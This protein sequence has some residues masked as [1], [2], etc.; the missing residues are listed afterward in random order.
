MT[1]VD[2]S[3][4]HKPPE[5]VVRTDTR[6]AGQVKRYH[7]WPC[8]TE[9]NIAEHTWDVLRIMYFIWTYLPPPV[10]KHV[11][12]HDCGEL[13]TG[14]LPYP[15]K[16][17]HPPVKKLMDELEEQSLKDQ[18]VDCPT[19]SKGW[20]ARV[21]IAHT[22]EMMEFAMH[23]L[24]LGNR[25]AAYVAN[26]MQQYLKEQ[27][28]DLPAILIADE[29]AGPVQCTRELYFVRHYVSTREARYISVMQAA[30]DVVQGFVS[31]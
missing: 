25:Y 24:S 20:A 21:K 30:T 17:L 4:T 27:L 1:T 13:R 16:R 28:N 3:L 9:Q 10:A 2:T 19:I 29:S 23:E 7:T 6:L 14:D 11:M 8:I 26:R 31:N 12:F 22:I 5:D 18:G 15:I